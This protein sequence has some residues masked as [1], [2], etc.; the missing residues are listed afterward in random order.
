M[1][2]AKKRN[3]VRMWV[4]HDSIISLSD[5]G[6]PARAEQSKA[7]GDGL[8]EP[9]AG[10]HTHRRVRHPPCQCGAAGLLSPKVS[11]PGRRQMSAV[12][13]NCALGSVSG[14]AGLPAYL[15]TWLQAASLS[16]RVCVC[17]GGGVRARCVCVYA[18]LLLRFEHELLECVG[19]DKVAAANDKHQG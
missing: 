18:D 7:L 9:T 4:G 2:E 6:R 12:P 1:H 13:R 14:W 3:D 16:A 8:K 15:P 5:G 10:S 19:L 17:G 11:G